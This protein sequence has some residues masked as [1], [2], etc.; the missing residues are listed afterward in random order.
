MKRFPLAH[1]FLV[2]A[3]FTS[4]AGASSLAES[5]AAPVQQPNIIVILADDLGYGDLNLGI[6]GTDVFK[7]PHIRTPNLAKLASDGLVMTH[8]YAA[9]SVCSP[10][11]AGLLTGRTPNRH[12]IP[13]WINDHSDD[14]RIFLPGSETTIPEIL[15]ENGYETA[16][17]GKWHLNGADWAQKENW[18]G[19][20]GS[21]PNQQG[22]DYAFVTKENPHET[23]AMK[24]NA[25]F[26]PGDFYR[27]DGDT[28]GEPVGKLPGYSS[29]II[30]DQALDWLRQKRDPQKPYFLYLPFDAV[31]EKVENPAAFNALYDT[32]NSDKDK[33]YANVT[34]LDAQIGR[35]L[36]FLYATKQEKNTLIVF[37]SDNGP[38][39]CKV[40]YNA[41]HSY[42]TSYPLHGHKR[43]I[44]EGGIRV[45]GIVRWSGT[46]E[47][48]VTD[49]P[50]ST[51][52]LLPTLLQ[53]AGIETP[54]D[55]KL[56][57]TSILPHLKHRESITREKPLYWQ[58]SIA[59]NWSVIEGSGY[60]RRF[61]GRAKNKIPT[62]IV[63]I[64]RGDFV[65]RGFRPLGE[66]SP[67]VKP[68]IFQLYDVVNDINEATEL[69]QFETERYNEMKTELLAMWEAVERD[70]QKTAQAIDAQVDQR[71]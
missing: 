38:E 6:P 22:F 20:T 60:D 25:Q 63:A 24:H 4:W 10:S 67:F 19:W 37:S 62:P 16:I 65:L 44:F 42:G 61:D 28:V 64:R 31:H 33:Y 7:N 53:A 8:H 13:K 51:L 36:D 27:C 45:P 49:L 26:E 40:Y 56:D 5:E 41:V 47:P 39:V 71:L 58:N 52:D 18:T 46:I 3:L 43:Q 48:G 17:I 50:N 35:L 1:R 14:E 54:S 30:V 70:R 34:Y 29:Q 23:T 32:G 66:K 69:S 55:L 11:R 57:G 9:S 2:V 15:Q 59:E 68:E 21:F 12:N